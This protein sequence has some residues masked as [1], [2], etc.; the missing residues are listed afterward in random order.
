MATLSLP[1]RTRGATCWHARLDS[2]V[3]SQIPRSLSADER[4]RADR[5]VFQRDRAHYIAAHNLLRYLL[6]GHTRR[7]APDLNI[8]TGPYGKPWLND[9]QGTQFSLSHSGA[10]AMVAIGNRGALGVDVEQLRPVPD[11][12]ALAAEHCTDREFIQLAS[13][14]VSLRSEA[15]LTCWTRKEACLK[16]LGKGLLMPPK[17]L[18]V[19]IEPDCREV[20]V[21]TETGTEWLALVPLSTA[22]ATVAS[23]AEWPKPFGHQ[24][25]YDRVVMRTEEVQP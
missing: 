25:L 1:A 24:A 21:Q 6:A 22:S 17:N 20:E 15:F 13:L 9:T 11:A 14:P 5:F 12:M 4:A 7:E 8:E 16:A 3:I 18:E 19:G 23:L 2:L 10:I